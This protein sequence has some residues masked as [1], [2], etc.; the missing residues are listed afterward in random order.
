[1]ND[2]Y[3]VMDYFFNVILPN[4]WNTITSD[5]NFILKF[6]VGLWL[7]SLGLYTIKKM[8]SSDGSDSNN[9]K[10]VSI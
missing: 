7:V 8:L 3:V 5:E 6:A 1:M 9:T 4:T 2:F 10:G